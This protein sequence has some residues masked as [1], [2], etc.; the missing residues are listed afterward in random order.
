MKTLTQANLTYEE[1]KK[2][3]ESHECGDCG[4]RLSI[5]WGGMHGVDD[6]IIRCTNN[7]EHNSFVRPQSLSASQIPG[8]NL[9]ESKKQRRRK[10]VQ[11]HGEEKGT[12][13]QKFLAPGQLSEKRAELILRTIWDKASDEAVI[14]AAM[15][16]FNHGLDPLLGHVFLIPFGDEWAVVVGIKANR[17]MAGQKGKY[18]Y[19]DDSPRIMT[20]QEQ[21]KVFGKVDEDNIVAITV[22]QD[23][24]R[25]QYRGY[26][27]YQKKG[28]HFQGE[29]KGN[30]RENMA[31]IRSERQALDRFAPGTLPQGVE[32]VDERFMEGQFKEIDEGRKVVIKTGEIVEQKAQDPESEEETTDNPYAD[33]LIGCP[34]HSESWLINKKFGTRFHPMPDKEEPFC[35]FGPQIKVLLGE[36]AKK[37]FVNPEEELKPW[38][39]ENYGKTKSKFSEE[40]WVEVL[41]KLD[42]MANPEPVPVQGEQAS[43][44]PDDIPFG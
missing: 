36:L 15:L 25:L 1:A 19:G 4:S 44:G 7:I 21:K 32:V 10:L 34:E 38:L 23:V 37:A 42:A 17:L 16:C 35:N 13:L 41:G 20:D 6:E 43:F 40:E 24:D 8:F 29:E 12:A 11:E 33:L 26:G 27:R 22:L 30:S 5:A 3:I 39:K 9:Y 18:G 2:Y 14:K 31:M 28:G